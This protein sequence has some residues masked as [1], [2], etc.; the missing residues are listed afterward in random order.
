MKVIIVDDELASRKSLLKVINEFPD[1]QVIAEISDG[2][3]AIE[4]IRKQRP[5]LVFLDID[6]PEVG[7]FDVAEATKDINYQL[8]FLTAYHEHALQAFDTHAIDYL[9]KP[10]RPELITKSID[11]ILRQE[12]FASS[13][14]QDNSKLILS[15][16]GQQKVI[17]LDHISYIE[18]VA[19]Y[20]LIHLTKDGEGYH[21]YNSIISGLSLEEFDSQLESGCFF[22]LHRSYIVNLKKVIEIRLKARR[23]FAVL[24]GTEGLVPISRILVNETKQRIIFLQ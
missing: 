11:K 24:L 6:M 7:G 10:A 21:G 19:R 12:T 1:M 22:R 13:Q 2:K 18:S 17:E 5:D 4:Q 16:G 23:H 8:I 14:I 15:E 9:I 20:R 3:T